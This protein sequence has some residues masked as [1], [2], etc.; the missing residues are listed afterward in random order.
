MTLAALEPIEREAVGNDGDHDRFAHYTLKTDSMR[1][2]FEGVAITALC[3]KTWVPTRD[4]DK[5]P[6]CPA[7]Q[8]AFDALPEG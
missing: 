1:G 2:Y 3:G 7:C 6:T 8:E 5:Y 4:P